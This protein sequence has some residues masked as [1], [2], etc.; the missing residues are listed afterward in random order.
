MKI[1]VVSYFYNDGTYAGIIGSYKTE[2][3]ANSAINYN[4]IAYSDCNFIITETFLE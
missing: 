1:Y 3:S 2:Q 4:K